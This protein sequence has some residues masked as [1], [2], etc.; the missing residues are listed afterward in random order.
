MVVNACVGVWS[1]L[2][3]IARTP[4]LGIEG[5]LVKELSTERAR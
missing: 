4:G 5:L 2:F 1:F 3:V